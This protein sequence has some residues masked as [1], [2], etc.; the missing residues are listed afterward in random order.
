MIT[1]V[2]KFVDWLLPER[3]ARRSI[4]D[5][6]RQEVDRLVERNNKLELRL[7]ELEQRITKDSCFRY[8]CKL[9][10]TIN[11]LLQSKRDT[12]TDCSIH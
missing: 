6:L 8:D 11:Q 3:T 1:I 5:E 2:S 10:I 9:R 4:I 12:A 7:D